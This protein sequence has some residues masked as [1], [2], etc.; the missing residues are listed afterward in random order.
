MANAMIDNHDILKDESHEKKLK[1]CLNRI[2][3]AC[4]EIEGMDYEMYVSAHGGFNVMNTDDVPCKH[5]SDF[6][7][8]QVVASVQISCMDCGD[9]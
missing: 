4:K 7:S 8:D 2:A 3:K 1:S 6:H 9:W 5:G